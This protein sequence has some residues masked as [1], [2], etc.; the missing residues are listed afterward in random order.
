[1]QAAA[2]DVGSNTLR[3]LIGDVRS[4][5]L[6]RLHAGR[7]VTRLAEQIGDTGF[8]R[9]ENMRRS[10][11]ALKDFSRSISE[12]GVSR[13]RAVGTSALRDAGNSRE[14]VDMVSQETGIPIE[15]ITGRREAELT[16]SG[17]F[18]G[19]KG[20]DGVSLI[21]DIGG[22]STEW[23]LSRKGESLSCGSLH[24]GVVNLF[25]RFIR[26]DPPSS[27]DVSSVNAEIDAHLVSLK[28]EIAR[29]ALIPGN[30]IGTGGTITTL[31]AMDLQLKEYDPGKVHGHAIPHARLAVLRDMLLLMPLGK[32]RGIPG[33]E[34]ERA[35]LII[36]G[37]LL[38]IRLMDFGGFPEL[39]VSDY[40]LLEGLIK[41]MNDEDSL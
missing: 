1:M 34:P 41:E 2:I 15:I 22:G 8:L 37:I 29:H 25:E 20:R 17:I 5:I 32:R 11:S 7:T 19:A 39:E 31:A 35:D 33:L 9:Q 21:F 28:R 40:G 26:T 14:F 13:V 30:I 38:T 23:I 4:N 36:P 6:S 3:L 18:M 27:A 24:I 16:A 12:H 10:V